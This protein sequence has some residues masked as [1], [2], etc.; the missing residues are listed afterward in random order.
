MK[1]NSERQRKHR[2][3]GARLISTP[4][5]D[6]AAKALAAIQARDG[7]T[8]RVAIERAL[9]YTAAASANS[10]SPSAH[11]ITSA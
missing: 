3:T 2:S 9:I 5:S 8:I 6:E 1:S 4:I 11:A 7:L 10:P